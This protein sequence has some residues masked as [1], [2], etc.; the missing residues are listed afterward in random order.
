MALTAGR[1]D[2]VRYQEGTHMP[3]GQVT[4]DH[5]FIKHW[6]EE[7]GG[8]PATVAGTGNG[9]SG[10]LRIDFPGFAGQGKL[11][12]ISWDEFFAKFDAENLAF[13]H[14]DRTSGGQP[15]RFNKFI[16]SREGARRLERHGERRSAGRAT[17]ARSMGR[18]GGG[19][20]APENMDG[21]LLLEH[22]YRAVEALFARMAR[23]KVTATALRRL[24]A[25]VADMLDGLAEAKELHFYPLLHHDGG[26][27]RIDQAID[28]HHQIRLML[29]E[30]MSSPSGRGLVDKLH[31]LQAVVEEHVHEDEAEVIPRA[32]KELSED[33][34]AGLAQEMTATIVERQQQGDLRK[35]LEKAAR[36]ASHR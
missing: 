25:E 1:L 2:I 5:D 4:R 21:L 28:E 8:H 13:L 17:G 33:Q 16:R 36:A 34:L 35:R 12:E 30:I 18:Q 27:G 9:D 29:A 24:A 11:R 22:Q 6:V 32:R 3:R 26:R 7:R 15:S 31:A 14:Q 20:L 23:G 10:L 19:E